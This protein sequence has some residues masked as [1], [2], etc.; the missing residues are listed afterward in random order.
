MRMITKSIVSLGFI[1]ALAGATVTT[2]SAQ[3]IDFKARA[4]T[5][6]F[7]SRRTVSVLPRLLR[8]Q[9]QWPCGVLRKTH[10][11]P[12]CCSGT[13]HLPQTVPELG[14]SWVA[15]VDRHARKHEAA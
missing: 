15:H 2:S 7:A 14:L 3:G 4:S 13:T 5:W 9:L 11:R 1:G 12:R 6:A 10:L 8:L